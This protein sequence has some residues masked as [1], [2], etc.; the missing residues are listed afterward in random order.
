VWDAGLPDL[1]TVDF[2]CTGLD[3]EIKAGT[4]VRVTA[5]VYIFG[6]RKAFSYRTTLT[7]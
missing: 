3:P 4:E 6:R 2:Q 5:N 7:Y 1:L